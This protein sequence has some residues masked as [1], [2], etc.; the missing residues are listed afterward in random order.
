LS[1]PFE[2]DGEAVEQFGAALANRIYVTW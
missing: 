2:S 1:E